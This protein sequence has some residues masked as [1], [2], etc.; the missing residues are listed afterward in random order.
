[1]KNRFIMNPNLN[2]F[3]HFINSSQNYETDIEMLR[4][5]FFPIH[6]LLIQVM[7]KKL[8]KWHLSG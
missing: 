4:Y 3:E 8:L 5:F 6:I 2:K 1:M 7:L